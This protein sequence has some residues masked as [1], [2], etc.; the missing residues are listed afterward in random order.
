MLVAYADPPYIGMAAKHYRR[1]PDY[2]GEVDHTAL[3]AR[4]RDEFPDGWALSCASTS[5]ATLLPLCPAKTRVAAWVKPYAT[6]RHGI[7]PVYSWEPVIVAGGR[8]LTLNGKNQPQNAVLDWLKCSPPM[9][10]LVGKKPDQFC[11]WVF[12]LLGLQPGD[13]LVDIYPGTGG[14]TR[15]WERWQRQLWAA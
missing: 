3:V 15:A 8:K 2:A 6:F 11:F 14:V 13:T 9:N 10:S 5:L 4:L 1:H 7:N 12:A